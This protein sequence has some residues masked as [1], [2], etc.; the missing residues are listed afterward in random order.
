MQDAIGVLHGKALFEGAN[1]PVF[2]R[3]AESDGAIWLDLVFVDI[4]GNGVYVQQVD[5]RAPALGAVLMSAS[6][7]IVAINA[8]LLRRT[9]MG[10]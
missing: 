3:L 2:V 5:W 10:R 8:Q 4:D 7:V 9:D 1:Q 6:T